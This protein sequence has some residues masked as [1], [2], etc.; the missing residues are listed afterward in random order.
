VSTYYDFT[1]LSIFKDIEQILKKTKPPTTFQYTGIVHTEN[2]NINVYKIIAVDTIRNYKDNISDEIHLLVMINNKDYYRDIYPNANNL[3][4]SFDI[5]EFKLS[6]YSDEEQVDKYTER[7]KAILKDRENKNTI[8]SGGE[9]LSDRELDLTGFTEV[10]FQL[11]NRILEPLR[12]KQIKGVFTNILPNDIL[13]TILHTESNKILVDGKPIIESIDV[14]PVNNTEIQN[15]I[16]I[17][18]GTML[19]DIPDL[20]QNE[21]CGIYGSGLGSYIQ[22]YMGKTTWFV[23]PLYNFK[24]FESET[25]KK[26]IFYNTDKS[27]LPASEVTYREEAGTLYVMIT[28]K[29]MYHNDLDNN[30]MESGVGFRVPHARSFMKKP[31]E[32]SVDSVKF[33]RNKLNHE[34]VNKIRSDNLNYAPRSNKYISSNPYTDYTNI[35]KRSI[36]EIMLEWNHSKYGLIYPGMPCKF[37]LVAKGELK[38]LYGTIIKTHT[39]I[40]LRGNPSTSNTYSTNTVVTLAVEKNTD[41]LKGDDETS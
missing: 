33:K 18:S 8:N 14:V 32:L 16:V 24:R 19:I 7:F 39:M 40:S 20:L 15:N 11:L 5:T 27:I 17:N 9:N 10:R 3:E 34:I 38:E 29:V 1:Q 31:V 13:Q 25:S 6:K 26:I 28:G 35:A 30:Y 4:F 23:F 41:F 22:K 36:S 2:K 21:Y 12:I 37:N